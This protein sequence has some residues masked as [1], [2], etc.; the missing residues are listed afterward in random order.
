MAGAAEVFPMTNP[1]VR[2]RVAVAV[3][4]EGE[5]YAFAAKSD[6]IAS[7]HARLTWI[8]ADIPLPPSPAVVEGEVRP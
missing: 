7:E 4:A 6:G 5:W 2:V 3:D 8:E 1:T